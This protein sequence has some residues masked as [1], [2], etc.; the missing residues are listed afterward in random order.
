MLNKVLDRAASRAAQP[1]WAQAESTG[2]HLQHLSW[3]D[4]EHLR[5]L[6]F[7]PV[8]G[9]VKIER[10][11]WARRSVRSTAYTCQQHAAFGVVASI[12]LQG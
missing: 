8:P 3:V 12:S 7:E 6:R 2:L 1:R 10:E 9:I 5:L 4:P 11:P